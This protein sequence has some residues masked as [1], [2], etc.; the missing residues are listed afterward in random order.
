MRSPDIMTPDYVAETTSIPL[1]EDAE[2]GRSY[3]TGAGLMM[4]DPLGFL[5]GGVRGGLLEAGSRLNPLLK[6]PLE[7]MAGQSF[8]Q[9]GP[10][11]GRRLEDLDP[12]IGR[13]LAIAFPALLLPFVI[14][15]AVVEGVATATEVS[16]S[17]LTPA[18]GAKLI[19][20]RTRP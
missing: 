12:T 16:R 1:G 8:F 6:A 13:T 19:A 9:K 3:L 5:G 18:T 10:M 11:G 17:A 2:G 15:A 4:E 20:H 14:R 7:W